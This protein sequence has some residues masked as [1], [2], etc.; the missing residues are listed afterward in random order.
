MK[1]ALTEKDIRVLKVVS[2]IAGGFV[3]IVALTM[4]FT[5]IQLKTVNPLDNPVLLSVKEQYDKSSAGQGHGSDGPESLF[6][7]KVGG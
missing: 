3:L 1:I 2:Q 4:I 5:L 6:Q 7:F